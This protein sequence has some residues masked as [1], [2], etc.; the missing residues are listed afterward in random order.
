MAWAL[1]R[2]ALAVSHVADGIMVG[3]LA[4]WKDRMVRQ[5]PARD[6]EGT[7]LA[8]CNNPLVRTTQRPTRTALLS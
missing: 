6:R 4:R 5:T 1:V 7:S 2:V 3:V 8:H